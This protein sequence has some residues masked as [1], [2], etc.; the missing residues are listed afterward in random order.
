M[1]NK[2]VLT[3]KENRKKSERQ[4][5]WNVIFFSHPMSQYSLN[6]LGLTQFSFHNF[7]L[8]HYS[9]F[10]DKISC[11]FELTYVMACVWNVDLFL[12]F[13]ECRKCYI[14]KSTLYWFVRTW[15]W[16]RSCNS[17]NSECGDGEVKKKGLETGNSL[18]VATFF[19]FLS[20]ARLIRWQKIEQERWQ[21]H[22]RRGWSIFNY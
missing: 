18:L 3:K 1:S 13:Y 21:R 17:S 16:K 20:I 15:K 12:N 6:T 14:C 5:Y 11:C 8:I 2:R 10:V 22:T 4:D 7:V 9:I 19:S